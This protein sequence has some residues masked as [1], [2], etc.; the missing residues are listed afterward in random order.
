MLGGHG[1]WFV[2]QYDRPDLDLIHPVTS[3]T[4]DEAAQAITA[5]PVAGSAAQ[6]LV[7]RRGSGTALDILPK[8][9]R[10]LA[11]PA[12]LRSLEPKPVYARAPDA[13]PA[14]AA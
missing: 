12:R 5:P 11:L 2:A 6:A 13:K 7:E 9:T 8:A 14:A 10:A 3:M 1:Q 4:P